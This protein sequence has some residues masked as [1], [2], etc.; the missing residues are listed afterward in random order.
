M[1]GWF[2]AAVFYGLGTAMVWALMD[3]A[4]QKR[5]GAYVLAMAWPVAVLVGLARE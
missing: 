1:I 3:D 5:P 4:G 2:V